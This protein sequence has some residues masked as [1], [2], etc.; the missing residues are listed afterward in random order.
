MQSEEKHSAERDRDLGGPAPWGGEPEALDG[1]D[2]AGRGFRSLRIRSAGPGGDDLTIGINVNGDLD[3]SPGGAGLQRGTSE[4]GLSLVSGPGDRLSVAL[5]GE[6]HL[7][8]GKAG[9]TALGPGPGEGSGRVEYAGFEAKITDAGTGQGGGEH[10]PV[11][12]D[13]ELDAKVSGEEIE[14]GV[15]LAEVLLAGLRLLE[16]GLEVF[17]HLLR[18]EGTNLSVEGGG[19]FGPS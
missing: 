4:G 15:L 2:D 18:V 13:A 11:L 16:D 10:A 8:G 7:V 19:I 3:G 6:M 5:H 9:T 14:P 12:A 17:L 1:L